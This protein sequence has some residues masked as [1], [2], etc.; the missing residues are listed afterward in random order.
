MENFCGVHV[1]TLVVYKK[2]LLKRLIS[3][4]FLTNTSQFL[5]CKIVLSINTS[6]ECWDGL[7]YYL[8][9]S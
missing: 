2:N 5:L 3:R 4:V 9:L 6:F 7:R 1:F 8:W